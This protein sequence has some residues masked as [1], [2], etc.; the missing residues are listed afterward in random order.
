[1]SKTPLSSYDDLGLFFEARHAAV[2]ESATAFAA[3]WSVPLDRDDRIATQDAA[4]ALESRGEVAKR[5]KRSPMTPKR[6]NAFMSR[7]PEAPRPYHAV[8]GSRVNKTILTG[9]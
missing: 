3:G 4:R 1:M 8:A 5:A 6:L 9:H 7:R 2:A